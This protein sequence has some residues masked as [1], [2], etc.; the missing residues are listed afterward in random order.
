MGFIY[1]LNVQPSNE[2]MATS[3]KATLIENDEDK[4][5]PRKSDKIS[6]MRWK[7]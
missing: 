3:L 4:S 5:N 2:K 7:I 1:F 6:V